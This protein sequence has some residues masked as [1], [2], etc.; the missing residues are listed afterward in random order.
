M[1]TK[2][3]GDLEHLEKDSLNTNQRD[4]SGDL[5]GYS[6]HMADM[7]TD[8]FDREFTLGLAS[9]EQKMLNDI[10]V[11]LR[12]LDDGTYGLCEKTLKPITKKRLLAVPYAR[13]CIEAQEMEEKEKRKG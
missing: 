12:K 8:N 4:A 5:S 7:A 1:R 2:N 9:N 13:L 3:A 6:F 11:A 10:D